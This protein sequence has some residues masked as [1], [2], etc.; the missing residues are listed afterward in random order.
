MATDQNISSERIT[1]SVTILIRVA[2]VVAGVLAV[3][4]ANWPSLFAAIGALG[5]TY[6]PRVLA[7]SVQ[8]RLPLQFEAA[9]TIFLYASIFLGEVGGYYVKYWWWDSVL[10][11][12]SAFAFG[13]AGFLILFLIQSRNKLQ[14]SPFLIS[15]FAFSFGL[16]TGALWE[17]FEYF[18]DQV[19]GLNM[20]RSGLRDTMWDLIIDALGAGGASI[21]GYINLKY[22]VHEPFDSF[23]G[24]FMSANPRFR[25]G[26][27]R[28]R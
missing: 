18:M 13:F 27:L 20:Q 19:F 12:G 14:A 8:V 28:R 16:A 24:W 9:I 4:T 11:V 17:I 10:H 26:L 7:S 6:I 2:L 5:L 1:S 21:I 23:I 22:N 3:M 15:I 25:R